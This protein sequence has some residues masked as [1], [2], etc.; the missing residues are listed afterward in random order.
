MMGEI[1]RVLAVLLHEESC[2]TLDVEIRGCAGNY[3]PNS[4][5]YGA[6]RLLRRRS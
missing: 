3:S 2:A 1:Q 4:L 5:R 6:K